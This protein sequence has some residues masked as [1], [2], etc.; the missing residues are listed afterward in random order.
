MAVRLRISEVSLTNT[1]VSGSEAMSVHC[2]HT[3]GTTAEN[4]WFEYLL[5]ESLKPQTGETFKL[6][7]NTAGTNYLL[8]DRGLTT[9]ITVTL[10]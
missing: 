10:S 9:S 5:S 8:V 2:P 1:G 4:N 6:P 3:S 7:L